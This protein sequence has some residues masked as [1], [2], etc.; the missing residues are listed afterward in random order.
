VLVQLGLVGFGQHEHGFHAV[1]FSPG[2]VP[3]RRRHLAGDVAAE[4]VDVGFA[5]PVQHRVRHP[6]PQAG[7]APVEARHVG[8]VFG[9]GAIG[10]GDGIDLALVVLEI[11]VAVFLRPRV[12]ERGVVRHPVDDHVHAQPVRLFDQCLEVVER[13]EF[14]IDGRVIAHG[15]IAAQRVLAVLFADRL[16]RHQPQDVHA[17]LFQARQMLGKCLER[18]LGRVLPDVHFVDIGVARPAYVRHR[19]DIRRLRRGGEGGQGGA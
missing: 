16:D 1:E 8:P 11:P 10:V 2:L 15:V 5:H 7:L 12:V 18:A 3:E 14:R 6:F 17:H 13:A 9:F 4:T 19:R